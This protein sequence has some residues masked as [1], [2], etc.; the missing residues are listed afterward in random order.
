MRTARA[1]P[2][3]ELTPQRSARLHV[4]GPVDRLVRHAHLQVVGEVEA[5]PGSDLLR[6]PAFSKSA[7]N[8]GSQPR[9]ARKLGRLRP[10]GQLE[11]PQIS[12]RGAIATPAA[13]TRQLPRHC[14]CRPTEPPRDLHR[15]LTTADR[16]CDLLP[17]PQRQKPGRAPPLVRADPALRVIQPIT[18]RGSQPTAPATS[19]CLSPAPIRRSIS[20]RCSSLNRHR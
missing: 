4:Q 6:R 1:Q 2:A 5:K 9:A 19:S 13:V 11:R 3:G 16:E 15:R 17:F 18:L 8:L 7:L 20:S 14:R 12:A 10:T